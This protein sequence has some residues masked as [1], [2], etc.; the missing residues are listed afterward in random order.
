MTNSAKYLDRSRQP[1]HQHATQTLATEPSDGEK[2]WTCPMHPQIVQHE[3]GECPVCGMALEPIIPSAEED[4]PEL[5]LMTRRFWVS[6]VLSLPLIV[7]AMPHFFP[8]TSFGQWLPPRAAIWLQ[9]LLATPVVLWGGWPFF[10]RGWA[11]VV[12][13]I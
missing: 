11:S 7:L 12:T 8:G 4:N 2:L 13:A 6:V 9:F 3:P 10:K 5:K 1:V